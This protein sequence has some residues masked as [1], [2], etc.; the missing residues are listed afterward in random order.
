[1]DRLADGVERREVR[2]GGAHGAQEVRH[3]GV[4]VVLEV[5]LV[6]RAVG[7]E[8]GLGWGEWRLV[9]W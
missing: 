9:C 2:V 6:G 3:S 1:M 7:E 4:V 5:Q 8:R